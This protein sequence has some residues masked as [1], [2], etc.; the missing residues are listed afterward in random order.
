MSEQSKA[1]PWRLLALLWRG[2]DGQLAQR[3]VSLLNGP[4]N[5]S[6][7]VRTASFTDPASHIMGD[8]PGTPLGPLIPRSA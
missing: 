1:R 5:R 3:G 4:V 6:W 8:R 7:G 2:P